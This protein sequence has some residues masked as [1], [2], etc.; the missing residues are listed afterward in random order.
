MNTL[1]QTVRALLESAGVR[2]MYFYP[3]DWSQ[4][5]VICWRESG[6]REYAQADGREYL[7]ELEYTVDV[8]DRSP[9][10]CAELAGRV[11]E[12]LAS[13]RLRRDFCGDLYDASAGIYHR[14]MRYRCVVD[15][16]GNVFQ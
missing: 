16:A 14:S 7:T 12:A 2:V 3:A 1:N 11:H 5:P 10:R 8:W 13:V 15:G 9:A 6:S 4:L